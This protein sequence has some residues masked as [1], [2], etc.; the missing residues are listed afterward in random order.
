MMLLVMY[1]LTRS[2]FR[3]G[4]EWGRLA[5]LVGILAGVAVSGELLL[6]THGL[7]GL[8][9]RALWLGL[10]PALLAGTHFFRP[11]EI[12]QAKGLFV[13]LRAR[14]ATARAN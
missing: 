12:A 8:L 10:V 2:L 1:L 4:F 3:V 5:L 14:L 13:L 11:R 9:L 6:P 7:A